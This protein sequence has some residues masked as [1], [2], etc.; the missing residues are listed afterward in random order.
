MRS[1]TLK[2]S[3]RSC[4]GGGGGGGSGGGRGAAAS[5]AS[6]YLTPVSE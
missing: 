4:G 1:R 3:N 6:G 2:I 5:G